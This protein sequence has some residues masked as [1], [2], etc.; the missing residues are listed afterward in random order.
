MSEDG[1]VQIIEFSYVFPVAVVTVIG[2][3]YLTFALFFHVYAFNMAEWTT[4]QAAKA[5]GG[6]RVYWQLSGTSVDPSVEAELAETLETRMDRIAVIPGLSFSTA[7]EESGHGTKIT[8]TVS[9]SYLGKSLFRV[10]S[11]RDLLKPTEFAHNVDL[12]DDVLDDTGIRQK[13]E[14]VFG[15][16]LTKDKTY[17]VF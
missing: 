7:L 14:E 8:A 12:L 4:D 15:R 17:E 16:Y 10:Q 6:D 9:G 13:L 11:V 3:L 2:L 1:S 5:V